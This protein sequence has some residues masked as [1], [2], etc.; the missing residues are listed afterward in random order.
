MYIYTIAAVVKSSLKAALEGKGPPTREEEVEGKKMQINPAYL[1][2]ERMSNQSLEHQYMNI[3]LHV[4][5]PDDV[6]EHTEL[7]DNPAYLSIEMC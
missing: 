7:Q 3:T 6:E 5:P 4:A 2:I 1:P